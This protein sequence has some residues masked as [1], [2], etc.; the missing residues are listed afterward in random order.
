MA[1]FFSLNGKKQAEYLKHSPCLGPA[2]VKIGNAV[3]SKP[4]GV[5]PTHVKK[6]GVPAGKYHEYFASRGSVAPDENKA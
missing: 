6:A 1:I 3:S 5:P 4:D 2:F